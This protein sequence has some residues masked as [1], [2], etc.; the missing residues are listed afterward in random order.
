ME[1]K[2]PPAGT[3]VTVRRDGWPRPLASRLEDLAGDTVVVAA[4]M[5][6][7]AAL[8][9]VELHDRATVVWYHGTGPWE[10]EGEVIDVRA[11][12]VDVWYLRPLGAPV[13]IQRREYVRVPTSMPVHLHRNGERID[14]TLAEI[15]EGGGRCVLTGHRRVEVGD[16]VLV[17]LAE[18]LGDLLLNATVLRLEELVDRRTQLAVRWDGPTA[19]EADRLR[20]YAFELD[21]ERRQRSRDLLPR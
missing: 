12:P 14:A 11:D 18:P 21:A 15:S 1:S 19:K 8:A 13:R 3:R 9:P 5:T 7:S 20:R 2:L 17:G 16:V 4:P 10:L 6:S